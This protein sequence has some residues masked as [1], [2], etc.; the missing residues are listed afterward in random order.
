MKSKIIKFLLFIPLLLGIVPL[1]SC[2][3]DDN[4]ITI[5]EVTHSLFYAPMYV[6]KEKGLEYLNITF[7]NHRYVEN[8]SETI[9]RVVRMYNEGS[10][11]Y[12]I[13]DEK[14]NANVVFGLNYLYN[15][16]STLP[17]SLMFGT[18]QRMF[19]SRLARLEKKVSPEVKEN[20]GWKKSFI[21]TMDDRCKTLFEINS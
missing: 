13:A 17:D 5:A 12:I 14:K 3:N 8:P 9:G 7:D 4:K 18:P 21:E 1:S 19:I 10:P 16:N 15:P 20:L 11:T 2:K 6:A